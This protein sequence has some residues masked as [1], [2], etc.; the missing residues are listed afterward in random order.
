M[1][2]ALS[3]S[4][5][6]VKADAW[7]H[8]LEGRLGV[9]WEQVRAPR[10]NH[11]L[12]G[13]SVGSWFFPWSLRAN[14]LGQGRESEWHTVLL[15]CRFRFSEGL[16]GTCVPSTMYLESLDCRVA[17]RDLRWRP[18]TSPPS[19]TSY[20]PPPPLPSRF[21]LCLLPLQTE[22]AIA[23]FPQLLCQGLGRAA[24]VAFLLLA[25]DDERTS[26]AT[27]AA[28]EDTVAGSAPHASAFQIS[29]GGGAAVKAVTSPTGGKLNGGESCS[30]SGD[31]DGD[32]GS[33]GVGAGKRMSAAT[34]CREICRRV[35][36]FESDH[37]SYPAF[38]DSLLLGASLYRSVRTHASGEPEK[39]TTA[40]ALISLASPAAE[41]TVLNRG[42]GRD[43]NTAAAH[44][45]DEPY[46]QPIPSD[47]GAGGYAAAGTAAGASDVETGLVALPRLL[48][49]A[50]KETGEQQL[51]HR[52]YH[53]RQLSSDRHPASPTAPTS[54]S[55][56]PVP[57]SEPPSSIPTTIAVRSEKALSAA[58]A[59]A[60]R[61]PGGGGEA[62]AMLFP[63]KLTPLPR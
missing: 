28:S 39:E 31:C 17:L 38:L 44:G 53:R 5:L 32:D 43:A 40:G 60:A 23:E 30:G 48:A 46:Y 55:I 19:L 14:L 36:D 52:Q 18:C 9:P 12:F 2:L 42:S 49:L 3:P 6:R 61:G 20:P 22:Q 10:H 62:A 45:P 7:R 11:V 41:G 63:D 56:L 29:D 4:T 35:S 59:E 26:A 16:H 21:S 50:R 58:M 57:S 1:L 33:N 8:V 24:R 34:A 47:A 51:Q 37:P 15:W 27:I 13:C 25:L 54:C